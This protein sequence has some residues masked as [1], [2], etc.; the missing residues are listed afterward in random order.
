[1][2]GIGGSCSSPIAAY[3]QVQEN[4]LM[5]HGL[6]QEEKTGRIYEGRMQGPSEAGEKIGAALAEK[7]QG[8][9]RRDLEEKR[10][11]GKVWLVGA[12]PGDPGLFTVKGQGGSE[13]SPG[14]GI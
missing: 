13:E 5:L 2:R 7:I 9:I 8:E 14:G 3:A 11:Q 10:K 4:T 1:M 6:Y 12:G